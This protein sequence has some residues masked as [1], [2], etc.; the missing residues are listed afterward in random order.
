MKNLK[1]IAFALGLTL[2]LS[3]GAFA[4]GKKC[5]KLNTA[6]G[7]AACAK[8]TNVAAVEGSEKCS[9]EAAAACKAKASNKRVAKK[10]TKT[11]KVAKAA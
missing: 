2:S 10:S 11:V 8:A 7:N 4:E 5:C 9:K 1:T 6:N 3:A